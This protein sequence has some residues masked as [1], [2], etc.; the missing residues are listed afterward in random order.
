MVTR[1]FHLQDDEVSNPGGDEEFVA[2][3]PMSVIRVLDSQSSDQCLNPNR[4]D[5]LTECVMIILSGHCY[6]SLHVGH[7]RTSRP[8]FNYRITVSGSTDLIHT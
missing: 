2:S 8:V 7:A 1:L 3:L 4:G 5:L 6:P